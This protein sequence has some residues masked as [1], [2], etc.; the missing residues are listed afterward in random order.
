MQ[1][2]ED[3]SKTLMIEWNSVINYNAELKEST[4]DPFELLMKS[5]EVLIK[6]ECIEE[7]N[8]IIETREDPETKS[9]ELQ[10]EAKTRSSEAHHK[11]ICRKCGDVLENKEELKEHLK[12]HS[13]GEEEN[14]D[15]S[16]PKPCPMCNILLKKSSFHSHVSV[17]KNRFLVSNN[18]IFS[19]EKA[20]GHHK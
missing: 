6:V 12:K 8:C 5:D 18:S 20:P 9:E 19:D 16:W 14:P 1:Q 2:Q 13:E 4:V 3:A 10:H 17:Q 11:R 7:E 15:L